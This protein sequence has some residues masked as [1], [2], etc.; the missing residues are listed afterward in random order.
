[1]TYSVVAGGFVCGNCKTLYPDVSLFRAGTAR[2]VW[3]ILGAGVKNVFDFNVSPE[4]LEEL[5]TFAEAW[6]KK[7]VE[8]SFHSLPFLE[9][10]SAPV[11]VP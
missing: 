1:M 2:A 9:M 4:I 11:L 3:H 5:K 6:C 7:R 8:H 10:F